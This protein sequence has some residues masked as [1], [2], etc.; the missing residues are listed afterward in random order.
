MSVILLSAGALI[1]P[2]STRQASRVDSTS[3][4]IRCRGPIFRAARSWDA[5]Q[6]RTQFCQRVGIGSAVHTGDF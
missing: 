6:L 5:T 3:C 1:S 2:L 4:R